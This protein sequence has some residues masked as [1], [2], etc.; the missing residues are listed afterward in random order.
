MMP[1][2]NFGIFGQKNSFAHCCFCVFKGFWLWLIQ[3]QYQIIKNI[4]LFPF[5]MKIRWFQ[6]IGAE[7]MPFFGFFSPFLANLTSLTMPEVHEILGWCKNKLVL[8]I[9]FINKKY[10]C[11]FHS[12]ISQKRHF[13]VQKSAQH[14]FC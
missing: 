6:L 5:S 1:F 2:G 3:R 9:S 10:L 11:E 4:Y 8:S 12:Y 14:I 13:F 7:K